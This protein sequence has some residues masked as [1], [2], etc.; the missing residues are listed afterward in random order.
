MS[1]TLESRED[2]WVVFY[3]LCTPISFQELMGL[4]PK[5]LELR[6]AVNHTVHELIDATGVTAIP[7]HPLRAWTFPSLTHPRAGMIVVARGN[8]LV[9]SAS[10]DIHQLAHLRPPVFVDTLDEGWALLRNL[11][12]AEVAANSF[13]T[14]AK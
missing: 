1:I 12:A 7:E 6:N 10:K 8:N 11:I 9:R 4:Q 5:D 2:G 13:S 14:G 3:T